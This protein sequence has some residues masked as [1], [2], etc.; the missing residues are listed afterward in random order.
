MKNI[1]ILLTIVVMV[2]ILNGT[3]TSSL[4]ERVS[5][6]GEKTTIYVNGGNIQ[7][8][9]DGSSEH[10]FRYIQD[11][12][13]A[14]SD[15]DLIYIHQGTYNESLIISRPITLYGESNTCID[16]GYRPVI[17]TVNSENVTFYNL[18]IQNSGGHSDDMG[19]YIQKSHV[20][21]I[22]CTFYRT[23]TGIKTENTT[24]HRIEN[25]TF[26]NNGIGICLKSTKQ[27]TIID[28]TFGQNAIGVYL[29]NASELILRSS[30]FHT[31]G[32]AC[33]FLA[34][35][36]ISFFRCNISDN[37]V[38]HGGVFL[39]ACSVINIANCLFRHNGIALRM[40]HSISI[41][42]HQCSFSFNT[43]FAL[44]VDAAS[45]CSITGC[46]II[47][48]YR[49]GI[50]L[51]G[52]S[53]L[54]LTKNNIYANTLYGLYV[55]FSECVARNNYWGCWSGPSVLAY[56][57]G[58]RVH[59]PLMR[60]QCYP[61]STY[62]LPG[63]GAN[64]TIHSP[65]LNRVIQTP[66]TRPIYFSG[67]DEDGDGVPDWWETKWG[68]DPFVWENHTSLDPDADGLVNIEECY[69]DSYGSNP[70]KKDVFL[71]IDW[72]KSKD[73]SQSNKPSL[74]LI[75]EA[76]RTFAHHNITLHVDVGTYDGGEEIAYFSS[77]SFIDI[78][79]IYWSYFL[80]EDPN[81]P[82]KGIFRY[83]IIC[84][85]GPDV[86][87]P[88]MGWDQLDSFCI[89]AQQLSEQFP[90]LA[91]SQL[92][93]KASIH[94]LGHTLGLL[95]DLYDGIDNVDTLQPFS[96]QWIKY[97]NY[98][99]NMNYWYKYQTFSYSDGSHGPGDFDD[100]SHLNL[101]FFKNTIFMI[102]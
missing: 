23:R 5:V 39:D 69:V 73:L 45:T 44:V 101:S 84:D 32:R 64:W 50:Y 54:L 37:S 29:E 92:I 49:S 77:L 80:H 57:F 14:S 6:P 89:S 28:C 3:V 90:F 36:H 96:M 68:Y 34:S 20:S 25:C 58:E 63:T 72:M 24:L 15:Y 22:N 10:P 74:Q 76:E 86:N 9:W 97:R 16:G 41:D 19:L 51:S 26:S 42:V 2:L 62:V 1:R 93:L 31:N 8:P 43:H 91:R 95:A 56:G 27:I 35:Q 94:H 7:G 102:A 47:H 55:K 61:W 75:R 99:S 40:L 82:R 30:Y 67:N 4:G 38:N 46:D 21:I 88:F 60:M 11:G 33:F 81:N 53:T 52:K 70:F 48:G 17:F 12:I 13:N 83:G 59:M 66:F 65:Y 85:V 71:E 18:L 100:Y 98:R 87:F 79:D 78:I